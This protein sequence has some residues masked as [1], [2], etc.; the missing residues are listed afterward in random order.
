MTHPSAPLPARER[1][2][3]MQSA[4]RAALAPLGLVVSLVV[5]G[6]VL[7][8]R[9]PW[10]ADALAV[11]GEDGRL[12]MV[13]MAFLLAFGGTAAWIARTQRHVRPLAILLA[14]F[15][16]AVFVREHNNR[17]KD[18]VGQGVWQILVLVVALG[19]AALAWSSRAALPGAIVDLLRRP[20]GGLLTAAV[21]VFAYAQLFDEAELWAQLLP[22]TDVPFAVRRVT[23]EGFELA[24]YVFAFAS[25]L[26]WRV[27]LARAHAAPD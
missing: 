11:V 24:A 19:T 21:A 15:A 14:G 27:G 16:L 22:G 1:P 23:E 10:P 3:S 4:L 2:V 7:L 13:Q 12:E 17:L 25:S 8:Y 26:S 5:L 6:E 18:D 9:M 20:A